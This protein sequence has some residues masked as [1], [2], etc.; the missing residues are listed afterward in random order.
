M[1][2][3]LKT[4]QLWMFSDYSCPWC[5]FLVPAV[6]KLQREH[7]IV[8]QRIAFQILPDIPYTGITMD[9]YDALRGNTPQRRADLNRMIAK[10][11]EDLGL[12]WFPR[13]NMFSSFYAHVLSKWVIDQGIDMDRYHEAVYAAGYGRGE[14][15]GDREVLVNVLTEIG[16][17]EA[18]VAIALPEGVDDHSTDNPYVRR[19]LEDRKYAA[20]HGVH[21]VPAFMYQDQMYPGYRSYEGLVEIIQSHS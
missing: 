15:I 13:K 5:Y 4:D 10:I 14:N 17:P 9:Q 1:N 16:L 11:T 7:G 6:R 18:G 12:T 19:V 2:E 8:T 21:G 20:Q 3:K